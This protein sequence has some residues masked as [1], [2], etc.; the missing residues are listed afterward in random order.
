MDEQDVTV[1]R[2]AQS[3]VIGTAGGCEC[4]AKARDLRL[5]ALD[6]AGGRPLA[7]DRVDQ[8]VDGDHLVGPEQEHRDDEALLATPRSIAAPWSLRSSR[9]PSS[10]KSMVLGRTLR[11][12]HGRR[13]R[14]ALRDA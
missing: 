11:P 12:Y 4:A 13:S 2:R 5:D 14:K 3:R 7:P 1:A 8:S 9:G 10:R 6:G